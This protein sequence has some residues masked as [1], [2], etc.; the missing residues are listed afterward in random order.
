MENL[1]NYITIAVIGGIILTALTFI[2]V[3]SIRRSRES[4]YGKTLDKLRK[5]MV[6]DEKVPDWKRST[7][8]LIDKFHWYMGF[9][10]DLTGLNRQQRRSVKRHYKKFL[11]SWH[12]IPKKKQDIGAIVKFLAQAKC[13]DF[14]VLRY[15]FPGEKREW[16][17]TT[18][19]K[20]MKNRELSLG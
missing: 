14:V 2:I 18:G 15:L 11:W 10:K 3:K 5:N 13:N 4:K 19:K 16:Y 1:S 17:Q 8:E 9:P 12:L 6:G 20:I 7:T